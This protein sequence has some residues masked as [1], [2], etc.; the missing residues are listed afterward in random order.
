[1]T[2]QRRRAFLMMTAILAGVAGGN[3]VAQT[4]APAPNATTVA[5][6]K[7]AAV[8][9]APTVQVGGQTLRL[10]GKGTR[11]RA[12]VRVYDIGLYATTKFGSVEELAAAAGPKRLHIIT[13]RELTGDMLGVAMVQGMQ[14]NAPPGER[15]KLIAH[16]DRLSRIFGAE[17]SV[18]AGTSL[19]IDYLPGRGTAF[20]L[21]GEQKGEMVTDPTYFTAIARIWL[22]PKPADANLKDS[23][24]GVET[25]R[26]ESAGG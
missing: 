25:R 6:P 9:L 5:A 8:R 16:M 12:V 18:P 13:L 7:L 2:R 11:Y 14:D 17:P 23:L 21:N 24:L 22:G 10:N 20:F 4:A 26:P 1:M 15:I 3:V 19:T